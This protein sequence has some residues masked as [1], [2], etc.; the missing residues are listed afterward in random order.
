MGFGAIASTAVAASKLGKKADLA[1]RN[2]KGSGTS[3]DPTTMRFKAIGDAEGAAA[4]VAAMDSDPRQVT[5]QIACL[6]VVA[7]MGWGSGMCKRSVLQARGAQAV[8]GAM[9]AHKVTTP[10]NDEMMGALHCKS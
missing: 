7:H 9:A 4:L 3:H 5:V 2:A 1:S 6:S 10:Y 8:L